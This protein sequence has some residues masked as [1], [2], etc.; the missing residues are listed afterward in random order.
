MGQI[1]IHRRGVFAEGIVTVDDYEVVRQDLI[2][3]LKALRHPETGQPLMGEV[4]RREEICPG[5]RSERA[6]DILFTSREFSYQFCGGF[7]PTWLET[8]A[9]RRAD[10]DREGMFILSGPHVRKGA[11]VDA[12]VLDIAPT[13]LYLGGLPVLESMEGR[14]LTAALTEAIRAERPIKRIPDPGYGGG[15]RSGYSDRER[16]QVEDRLSKLGYL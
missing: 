13:L 5:S 7:G 9:D 2:D 16:R 11:R 15:G 12:S 10:H 14:V 1:F 6:P 3:R 4:C 8:D